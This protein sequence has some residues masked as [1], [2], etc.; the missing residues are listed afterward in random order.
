MTNSPYFSLWLTEVIAYSWLKMFDLIGVYPIQNI[1]RETKNAQ[2]IMYTQWWK[3]NY[4]LN[5]TYADPY[6]YQLIDS[7][8]STL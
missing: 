2:K 3:L 7:H 6:S 5:T 1:R 4:K 8:I